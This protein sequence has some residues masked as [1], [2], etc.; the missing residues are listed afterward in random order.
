MK[1]VGL[2]E[3]MLRNIIRESH[4]GIYGDGINGSFSTTGDIYGDQLEE[5]I[6]SEMLFLCKRIY[7][8]EE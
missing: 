7:G 2:T 8:D 6:K 1:K 3:S 5:E 4:K